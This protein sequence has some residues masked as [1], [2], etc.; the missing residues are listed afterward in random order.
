MKQLVKLLMIASLVAPGLLLAETAEVIPW[1]LNPDEDSS[2]QEDEASAFED[3]EGD[4]EDLDE[5]SEDADEGGEEEMA[6][7]EEPERDYNFDLK[8]NKDYPDSYFY[9]GPDQ[10]TEPSFGIPDR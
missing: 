5:Y 8:I 1:N 7:N 9:P 4:D 2:G 10:R 6:E 3:T